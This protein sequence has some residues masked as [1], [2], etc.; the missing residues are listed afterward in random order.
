MNKS[1]HTQTLHMNKAM[2]KRFHS[3]IELN[4]IYLEAKG[5]K[6]PLDKPKQKILDVRFMEAGAQVKKMRHPILLS[7]SEMDMIYMHLS[8]SS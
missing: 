5:L 6:F 7:W 1:A 4:S 2:S 3:F 8:V